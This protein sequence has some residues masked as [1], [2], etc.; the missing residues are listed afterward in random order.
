MSGAINYVGLGISVLIGALLGYGVTKYMVSGK[1]YREKHR[2]ELIRALV[3]GLI[4]M[5][6]GYMLYWYG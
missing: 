4:F 3:E 6:L 1:E 2:K 5:I